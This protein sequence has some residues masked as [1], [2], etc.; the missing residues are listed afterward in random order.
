MKKTFYI[1]IILILIIFCNKKS[2]LD[3]QIYK[4]EL[5]NE[6]N[7]TI[8][9]NN[10]PHQHKL[11]FFGY[12]NCPDICPVALHTMDKAKMILANTKI[13]LIFITIDPDRDTP[14]QIKS[15]LSN[16]KSP[17]IGI[18]GGE[19]KLKIIYKIFNVHYKIYKNE[20]SHKSEHHKN[21]EVY[22]YDH[23]PFIYFLDPDDNI[24]ATYPT[25]INYL[26]L[27]KELRTFLK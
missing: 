14:Q 4:V 11:V 7:E 18:T 25:G 20:S 24:I 10:L 2:N 12:T 22:G 15:Y 23:T 19:D 8:Y 16:F 27:A 21:H 17:I 26:T 6:N 9:W 3:P 13:T 5:I 1:F